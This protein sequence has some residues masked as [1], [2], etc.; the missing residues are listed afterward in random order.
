VAVLAGGSAGA[1]TYP[2]PPVQGKNA[3]SGSVSGTVTV[4][5]PG[6]KT[7]V[8]VQTGASIPSGSE[9]NATTGTV[10]LS[11]SQGGELRRV[12]ITG[13][14]VIFTQNPHTGQVLFTLALP[15]TGCP[16]FPSSSTRR[17][18]VERVASRRPLRRG[19]RNRQITVSD[20]GG[21]FGTKGQYVATSTEGTKWR[22]ADTCGSTTVTVY[23]GRVRIKNL[24]TGRTITI[25][26]SKHYT[27]H[28]HP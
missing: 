3:E 27:A 19:P 10:V 4:R 25:G 2:V 6:S 15:L 23:F 1:S 16:S 21:S 20:S 11:V 13:G 22:T 26:A 17:S 5:L 8:T 18:A 12:S 7:A 14:E 24:V 28:A 9:V